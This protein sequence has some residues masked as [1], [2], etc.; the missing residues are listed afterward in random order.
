MLW[1]TTSLLLTLTTSAYAPTKRR[2]CGVR[3]LGS[4]IPMSFTVCSTSAVGCATAGM[5]LV[6]SAAPPA[7][8]TAAATA[9]A[10]DT[11]AFG[12]GAAVV[13]RARHTSW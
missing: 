8:A 2:C 1:T 6:G 7:A 4:V 13:F 3:N 9:A 5:A 11:V 12:V 10:F